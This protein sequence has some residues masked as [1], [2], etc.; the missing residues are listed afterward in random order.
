VSNDL[1]SLS[2][3]HVRQLGRIIETLERSTFDFL[4]IEVGDLKVTVG[5]G[6]IPS[7]EALQ[8][9]PRHPA[10]S[11]APAPVPQVNAAVLQA[12]APPKKAQAPASPQEGTVEIKS[13]IMGMFYAQPEP[14]A[15]PFVTVGAMVQEDTT[16]GLVEVMKTFNAIS[17]G[18]RGKVVEVCAPNAQL[19]EYGQ[20]LFR[21]VPA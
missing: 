15:P 5:K 4:Q 19:V 18:V 13:A 17:A 2:E 14:G 3:D 20:V 8:S 10:P 21:V 16:V 6:N 1:S 11:V 12:P 9:P 7:P